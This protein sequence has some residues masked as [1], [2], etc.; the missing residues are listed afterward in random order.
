VFIDQ[1]EGDVVPLLLSRFGIADRRWWFYLER[2]QLIPPSALL[3][4]ART[5][6]S[7]SLVINRLD[8]LLSG[9]R[10]G[11]RFRHRQ[12]SPRFVFPSHSRKVLVKL[13]G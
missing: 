6:E 4:S 7:S 9:Q 12:P 8:A 13:P 11:W 10:A 1:T 3:E 2:N 5:P